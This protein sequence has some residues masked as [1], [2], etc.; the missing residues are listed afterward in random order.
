MRN[1]RGK[2]GRTEGKAKESGIAARTLPPA[3]VPFLKTET[4]GAMVF[5]VSRCLLL[6]DFRLRVFLKGV[7][8]QLELG[9]FR[10]NVPQRMRL[11]FGKTVPKVERGGVF[12]SR[13][14]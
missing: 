8:S 4:Q 2:K 10:S 3:Q 9:W 12:L 6:W 5:V 1:E 7:S 14:L 11:A 13:N